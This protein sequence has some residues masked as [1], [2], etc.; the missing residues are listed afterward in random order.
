MTTKAVLT[1]QNV[2]SNLSQSDLIK[3]DDLVDMKIPD[4]I[5]S[6]VDA[7]IAQ[8]YEF[9]PFKIEGNNIFIAC[10]NDNVRKNFSDLNSELSRFKGHIKIVQFGEDNV[11]AALFKY[12][13]IDSAYKYV[14]SEYRNLADEGLIKQKLM[15]IIHDAMSSRKVSDIHLLPNDDGISIF[16]RVNGILI[17]VTKKG[18]KGYTNNEKNYYFGIEEQEALSSITKQLNAVKSVDCD[19]NQTFKDNNGSFTE[20]YNQDAANIRLSTI[21]LINGEKIVFRILPI[22]QKIRTLKE[23]GYDDDDLNLIKRTLYSS[24]NGIYI[25]AG[26]TG[27]GKTTSMY[28]GMDELEKIVGHPLNII[29]IERPVE[30][31]NRRYCQVK[32][33]ASED[34]RFRF[35]PEQIVPATLRQNPDIF[36]YGEVRTVKD[37]LAAIEAANTGHKEFA[38]IHANSC[39][40]TLL[41][42]FDFDISKSSLLEQLNMII[43]QRLIPRLCPDCSRKYHLSEDDKSFL[44]SAEIEKLENGTLRR[45][46]TADEYIKCDNPDCNEGIV[47]RIVI[48]EILV[49]NKK[50]KYAF[51]RKEVSFEEIDDILKERNFRTIWDKGIDKV[52]Q[53]IIDFKTLCLNLGKEAE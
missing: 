13:D 44:S 20:T 22:N 47:G 43:S 49:F 11:K 38:T 9:V 17:D 28:A 14:K 48:P 35:L 45:C 16:F 10:H 19:I 25:Y 31:I 8:K 32:I 29:T 23:L 34:M 50:L 39:L 24:G 27:T 12:Y 15:G 51:M 37:A 30:I 18:L 4:E 33:N 26:G 42:L 1:R 7:N 52:S 40:D 5:I 36:I 2:T 41:R 3:K 46:G 21:P 53:G 6:T